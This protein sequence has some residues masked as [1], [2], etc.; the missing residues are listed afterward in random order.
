MAPARPLLV[1]TLA[2]LAA[3]LLVLRP[4]TEALPPAP[5][6]A[7]AFLIRTVAAPAPAPAP[8]GRADAPPAAAVPSRTQPPVPTRAPGRPQAAAVVATAREPERPA[9]DQQPEPVPPTPAAQQPAAPMSPVI[10]P[11]S[12]RLQYRVEVRRGSLSLEAHSELH[13]RQD[14]E[15]YEARLEVSAPL[16]RTRTQHSTGRITAEGLAPLRFS[17][18]GRGEEAAHFDREQRKVTFSSNR[19]DA[20]L[21]PGAQDRLSVLVQLGALVAGAPAKFPP[22]TRVTLQTAGTRDAEPWEFVVEGDEQLQLPGGKLLARKLTRSPRKEYDLKVELWL[23]PGMDY[24]PVRLRL[25]QPNG[26]SVDQQWSS[27]DRG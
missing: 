13:W 4:A 21:L 17:D 20:P 3:H 12:V 26:D 1:L 2:V 10:V 19:P 6:P 15:S 11:G 8:P 24:V 9:V 25:T 27:T 7:S 23:A 14:G 5:R 18:K 16:L 22:G